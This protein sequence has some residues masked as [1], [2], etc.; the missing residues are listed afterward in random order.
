MDRM[1]HEAG[2]TDADAFGAWDGTAPATPDT[3][4]LILRA[5]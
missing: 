2:F 1:L 4:R 5:R 3:W